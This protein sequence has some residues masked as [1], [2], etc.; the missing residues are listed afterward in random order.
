[1][2]MVEGFAASVSDLH[3]SWVIWC[4]LFDS[5][6]PPDD[7]YL[8][9]L[10]P[11]MVRACEP[12]WFEVRDLLGD[13]IVARLREFYL[14]S[15]WTARF[16]YEHGPAS[17]STKV[18]KLLDDAEDI[19]RNDLSPPHLACLSPRLRVKL[20]EKVV[21][22]LVETQE[23]IANESPVSGSPG[24]AKEESPADWRSSAEQLLRTLE[25]APA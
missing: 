18:E 22:L 6:S 8:A 11:S 16:V 17:K 9:A 19:V 21:R 25:G 2:T 13:R 10:P 12:F 4:R 15:H 1:M 23:I 20:T 3:R 7:L 24:A 14:E 5:E